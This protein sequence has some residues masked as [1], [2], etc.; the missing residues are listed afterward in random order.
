[1]AMTSRPF[2]RLLAAALAA[3]SLSIAVTGSAA[4]PTP[5]DKAQAAFARGNLDVALKEIESVKGADRVKGLLLKAKIELKT[6]KLAEAEKT[7]KTA[8]GLG[9]E[10]KVAAAPLRA[11][12]LAAQGKTADAITVLK[13]VEGEDGAHRAHVLLGELLIRS[14]KRGEA[15]AVLRKL[16]DAYN[17]DEIKS[18]DPEGLAL[19][20]RS[21]QLDRRRKDANKAFKESEAVGGKKLVEQL[22]WHTE[23]YLDGYDPADAGAAIKD[24]LK[25]A[26]K[27]PDVHVMFARVKLENGLDF[28]GAE[29][30]IN[31]ALEVNPGH[32]GAFFVRAGLA[33]RDLDIAAADA[34]VDTGLKVNPNDLELL[35]MKAAI[36]FL[37]DDAA[38]F[39]A[40]KTKV[41]A[42]NPEFSSF[43][44][45]IGEYAEW[46]HRYEDI[47]K[48]MQ[49]AV[50]I[51][52]RD[53]K[54]WATLGLNLIRSGD[55]KEGLVA[56][57]EA[58][59]KDKFNV[60]V[61]NTLNLYES[62]IAAN[63]V[64]VDGAH[65]RIRYAKDEQAI[66]ER[67]VP[68]MLEE[69]WKSM[70]TRYGFTP[71]VPVQIE[72]YADTEHF[73]VRTSGLPNVGIQGVCFGQT[74]AALSPAAAPF[75]W[76]NVIWHELGHVFAIQ[77]SKNHVPRWYTEGLSEYETIIRRPEWQREE[78]PAL[79]A[80]LRDGRIPIVDGFNRAFTH[81]DTAEDV[82]MA[83]FAASQIIVFAAEKYGFPKVVSMMPKWAAGK[84]TPD[85][86]KESL[87]VTS[88]ELD[89][90]F[91]AWLKPR[92]ARY[93]NQFLPD[94]RLLP[95]DDA[96][97]AVKADPKNAKKMFQLARS[98]GADGQEAEA[99]AM[100]QEALRA[101]PKQP[102][103]NFELVKRALRKK[104]VK[105]AQKQLE[106]MIADGHD[107]YDIRMKLADLAEAQED[108]EKMKKHLEAAYTLDTSQVE[109][110][111]ALYDLA[112][113]KKD[114]IGEL[115]A[116]RRIA[117]LDQHDRRVWTRLLKILVERGLWEEARKIG[118]GAIF[119]DVSNPEVHRLYARA[120]ARTGQQISAIF[121]LNSAILCHPDDEM[122]KEI[123]DD[124]ATGYDKLKQ[125]EFAK[126]AREYGKQ[127]TPSAPRGKGG[128]DDEDAPRGKGKTKDKKPSPHDDDA[129]G[130]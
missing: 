67:Y 117:L 83:Y 49:E 23:L 9:K 78:D 15:T 114:E 74:L 44:Q 68:R 70:V 103:A 81:V 89:K 113:K 106:K 50:K 41:F 116:L 21:A 36:R 127:V 51:D 31:Q 7:A 95:L 104:D 54:A 55:E 13:E 33:L 121:E 2:R 29:A 86:V 26:P 128:D 101:D 25:I 22:L 20:A 35:S 111:Q 80:A 122:L 73:S 34:A 100:F 77:L 63:Y 65:F 37:A 126:Q 75:N 109:P 118:E 27:D 124:L 76:G 24:A 59:K 84:R 38:G 94:R 16:S 69:A 88:E 17:A 11:Q 107:G 19:V 110:L 8:A 39:E 129:Q 60:R 6:G 64:T 57:N 43:Y 30:E 115:E 98:L 40:I 46:E 72:L 87:G 105:G 90:Q 123:Y 97:K 119:V 53:A 96:R 4:D 52:K 32:P 99:E 56:L 112:H 12:A 66:L 5:L 18:T 85:V 42:L 125:P 48:M 10:A 71:K 1:M 45:I 62:T 47:V 130:T 92:L 91:R 14:G 102:D 82:T 58:H 79:F 120:L 3:A 61:Y 93:E 28:D 108:Q